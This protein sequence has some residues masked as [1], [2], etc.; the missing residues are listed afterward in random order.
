MPSG[1][2]LGMIGLLSRKD[3]DATI[4]P[5]GTSVA[6]AAAKVRGNR[7]GWIH[8]IGALPSLGS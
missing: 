8:R 1:T 4:N 3:D 7:G 6:E 2:D 5:A